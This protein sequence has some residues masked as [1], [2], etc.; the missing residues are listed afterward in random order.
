MLPSRMT[1]SRITLS[2]SMGGQFVFKIKIFS[3]DDQKNV[4]IAEKYS[5]LKLMKM[6][7]I[8]KTCKL[9]EMWNFR[10]NYVFS[11]RIWLG[12]VNMKEKLFQ[13]FQVYKLFGFTLF[14]FMWKMADSLFGF[15][16]PQLAIGGGPSPQSLGSS[17][18]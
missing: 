13:A 7:T 11:W 9:K 4:I 16:H 2:R 8:M 12:L 6:I 18:V 17:G 10:G 1:S 3:N 15:M 5:N 14:V